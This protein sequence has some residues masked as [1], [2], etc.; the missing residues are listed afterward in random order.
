METPKRREG[1]F[2]GSIKNGQLLAKGE[3]F[4]HQ[5]HTWRKE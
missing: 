5:L 1:R 2:Y 3:D 4:R